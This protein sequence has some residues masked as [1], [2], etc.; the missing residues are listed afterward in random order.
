LVYMKNS[1]GEQGS[2]TFE[3][4]GNV[5]GRCQIRRAGVTQGKDIRKEEK[6]PIVYVPSSYLGGSE[7]KGQCFRHKSKTDSCGRGKTPGSRRKK[8]EVQEKSGKNMIKVRRDL[9]GEEGGVQ[10]HSKRRRGVSFV[11]RR[12]EKEKSC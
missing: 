12:P 1:H 6:G 3:A 11:G 9:T 4:E 8:E 10:L 5:R 7:E 2:K